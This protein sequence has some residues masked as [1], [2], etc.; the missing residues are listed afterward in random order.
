[1]DELQ[2]GDIDIH[3]TKS[4][5]GSAEGWLVPQSLDGWRNRLKIIEIP[6]F[7]PGKDD[8]KRTHLKDEQGQRDAQQAPLPADLGPRILLAGRNGLGGRSAR[9]FRIRDGQPGR[10][11]RS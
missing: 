10:T 11:L 2:A 3:E 8:Q 5:D 9:G 1:M 4:G 6:V 7:S